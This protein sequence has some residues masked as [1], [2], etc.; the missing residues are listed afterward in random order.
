MKE[1][2]SSTSPPHHFAFYHQNEALLFQ[3]LL[4]ECLQAHQILRK[5]PDVNLFQQVTGNLDQVSENWHAPLGHLPKLLHYCTLL[6]SHFEHAASLCKDL[7]QTLERAYSK[8]KQCYSTFDTHEH[9]QHYADLRKE[10]LLFMK[11]LF[12]KLYDFRENAS[13]L[14]FLLHHQEQFD[15][16]YREPIIKKTFLAFFPDGIKQVQFFLSE[17]FSKK[18]FNHLIPYIEQKLKKLDL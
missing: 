6:S 10:M 2:R 13:V 14:Y 17:K 8:A 11:F 1:K 15:S 5:K 18:G 16:L 3:F 7:G 12:V 4:H 9:L